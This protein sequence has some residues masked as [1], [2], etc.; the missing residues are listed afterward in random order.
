MALLPQIEENTLA[1]EFGVSYFAGNDITYYATTAERFR[2]GGVNTPEGSDSPVCIA[3]LDSLGL[4]EF[5]IAY[6]SDSLWSYELGVKSRLLAGRAQLNAAVY[7]IDWSDMQTQKFLNCGIV[8]VENAGEV[9]SDGA[10]AE[11]VWWPNDQLNVHLA[12]SFNDA[13][14]QQD[15]PNL[16]GVAGD[17]IPGVPRFT[18][19]AA[20]GYTFHRFG[21]RDAFING[22]YSYVGDTF[23]EFDPA[24]RRKLPSY[25]IVNARIGLEEEHWSV[26]F[27]VE[28]VLDNRGILI[29]EDNILRRSETATPPRTIGIRARLQF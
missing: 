12:A 24:V 1:W 16:G 25:G 3:E 8:Y 4:A 17:Q 27:F 11:F 26:E 15:A 28:N 22:S 18:A 20:L 13:T 9:D 7:H 6:D 29:V 10:E 21:N 23:N 2:A 14:L 5:P 19:S